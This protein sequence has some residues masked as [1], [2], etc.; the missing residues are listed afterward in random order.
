MKLAD[1]YLGHVMVFRA[2]NRMSYGLLMD[3]TKPIQVGDILKHPDS[4]LNSINDL[5]GKKV[6]F[7]SPGSVTNMLILMCLKA[8]GMDAKD[9]KL[10]PAGD[11]GA[12]LSAVVNK[13]VDTGMS[14]EPIWSQNKSKVRPLFW[15]KDCFPPQM[16]Q[17]VGITTTEFA[18]TGADKLRAIIAAREEGVRYIIANPDESAEIVAKAYS[19]D[20][21]LYREVFRNFIALKYWGSGRLDYTAMNR[22]A[23]GMQLVGTLKAPPDWAKMVDP[24]FQPKE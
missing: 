24:A 5:V 16:T 8:A 6:A 9:L 17:T 12:N 22:M 19:G 1:E 21:A 4:T 2:W 15:V 11:I 23:E 10:L 13:A 14:G 18:A 3:G 7:T 20:A